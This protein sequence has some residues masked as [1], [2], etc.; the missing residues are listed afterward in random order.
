MYI[1]NPSMGG[2]GSITGGSG[3]ISGGSGCWSGV[4]VT[5]TLAVKPFVV[6]AVM[7]AV[8]TD[9]A[10]TIPAFDT[11]AMP[12]LLLCHVT[13]RS[14]A[15]AGVTTAVRFSVSPMFWVSVSGE[16][17]TSVGSTSAVATVM[18]AV[19]VRPFDVVA[20]IV[21]VPAATAVTTP[22]FDTVATP[23]LL[24]CQVTLRSVAFAGVTLATRFSVAPMLRETTEGETVTSVGKIT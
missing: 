16:T 7:V 15:L 13:L 5:V 11:V 10:V 9:T 22:A 14:V 17:V 3:S 23:L 20:V 12:L 6:V 1:I 18:V 8:P 21:A 4:T 19:A 24:L 2:S